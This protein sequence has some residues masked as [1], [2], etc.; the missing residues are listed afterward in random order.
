VRK[1]WENLRGKSKAIFDYEM[2]DLRSVT[3]ALEGAEKVMQGER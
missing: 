2:G 3:K 1:D